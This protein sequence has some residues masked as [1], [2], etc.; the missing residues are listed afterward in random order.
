MER[1]LGGR[2]NHHREQPD[3]SATAVHWNGN[4]WSVVP[5]PS[6]ADRVRHLHAVSAV[7]ATNVWAVGAE[8]SQGID[9]ALIEHWNG[10]DW[11]VAPA[12][13]GID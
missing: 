13:A 8:R 7:S 12:P 3:R 4:G 6:Q 9:E 11:S 10:S 5:T 1:H 2:P